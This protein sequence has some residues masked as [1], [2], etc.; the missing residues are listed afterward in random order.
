MNVLDFL[1]NPGAPGVKPI[2]AVVGDDTYLRGEALEAIGR[3]ATGEDVPEMTRFAGDQA[4]LAAVLDEVRT[5]P[6][7]SR[8]RVAVVEGAD[9]FVTAHRR[10]LEAF[11][12]RPAEA[13]T[14]VLAVKSWP[15]N[16]KLAK[17]VEKVGLTLDCK[18]PAERDLPAWLAQLA[19]GRFKVRLDE[20]AAHLLVELVGPEAGL[21]AAEVEKLATYV[22]ERK[23][24][25]RDD[26]SRMVGAGRVETIWKIL[27]AA[28]TG[29]GAEALDDLD[30]LLESGEHP[31][32][33]LAQMSSSLRRIHHAGQLRLARRNLKEAC[34]QA[35]IKFFAVDKV[36]HQ[37]AHLGPSRVALLPEL[38]LRADLD[39]KGSSPLAPRAV[40]ER[41]LLQL[42]RPRQD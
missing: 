4:P 21:L 20:D 9:P 29:R 27:D 40:L 6:F 33:L 22:G 3:A 10:E 24:I 15:S 31:V 19:K 7:L 17:L 30:R 37:H 12:E 39:L 13:G 36:Q 11:A 32:A 18:P 16:T 5:L 25:G 8:R 34:E 26:V 41:L 35:G 1:R 38:L 28:T 2:Y 23:S 14:L 42:A